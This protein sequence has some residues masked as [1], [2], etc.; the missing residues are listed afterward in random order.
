MSGTAFLSSLGVEA[1][2]A[3]G[4]GWIR[5][6]C[7]LA[8][9]THSS[10]RDTHPSFA[11]HW[12]EERY[13]CFTCGH[14]DLYGLL[15][16]LHR[17][18]PSRDI[19]AASAMLGD[20]A[21]VAIEPPGKPAG[22]K[23]DV[24]WTKGHVSWYPAWGFSGARDYLESRGVSHET[25][26]S[27][28]VGWDSMRNA[29]VFPYWSASGQLVG[30]RGR[31]VPPHDS[32]LRYHDYEGGGRNWLPWYGEWYADGSKPVVLVESVFDVAAVLPHYPNVI[33]PLSASLTAPKLAR[34]DLEFDVKLVMFDD[35]DAGHVAWEFVRDHSRGTV[36]RVS[37]AGY[38]DPGDM[39][40][41][42]IAEKLAYALGNALPRVG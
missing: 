7:P 25:A 23:P 15:L 34:V 16:R 42:V 4:S 39:P 38:G 20:K 37:C 3:S 19:G 24:P 8:Q 21:F 26:T 9:W 22:P 31:Y 14:G 29:V 33:A 10:G 2:R 28:A 36:K 12:D 41:G 6:R 18:D 30:A 11:L 27:L 35:D 17:H 32:E 40:P 5:A 1:S 13:R